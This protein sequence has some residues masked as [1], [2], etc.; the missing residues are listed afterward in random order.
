MYKSS[1]FLLSPIVV[2]LFETYWRTLS[3]S[4][5]MMAIWALSIIIVFSF[6]FSATSIFSNP[7]NSS[8]KSSW[9]SRACILKR[10]KPKSFIPV[11]LSMSY[12]VDG[13]LNHAHPTNLVWRS[14]GQE[15]IKIMRKIE[16]SWTNT[17]N[18]SI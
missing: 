3:P 15:Q 4:L 10:H 8:N 9:T 11:N 16:F 7:F 2:F 18:H 5:F 12:F 14:S 1:S 17:R 13:I 6:S